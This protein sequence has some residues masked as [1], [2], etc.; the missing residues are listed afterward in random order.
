MRV[1]LY[2]QYESVGD[3][4]NGSS[5]AYKEDT[6]N[7][8]RCKAAHN[9]IEQCTGVRESLR[10]IVATQDVTDDPSSLTSFLARLQL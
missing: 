7:G 4:Y 3:I 6:G 5:S 10:A 1:T 8:G 2:I 9:R